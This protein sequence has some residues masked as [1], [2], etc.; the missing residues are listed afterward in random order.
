[1]SSES[2]MS[3]RWLPAMF[4]AVGQS[5]SGSRGSERASERVR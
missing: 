1:M 3:M 2:G 4:Y 5:R